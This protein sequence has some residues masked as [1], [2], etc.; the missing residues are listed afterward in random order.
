MRKQGG[1]A[2]L[3]HKSISFGRC[4]DRAVQNFIDVG[5]GPLPAPVSPPGG[6]KAA[7]I[8]HG[9]AFLT[10]APR[11]TATPWDPRGHRFVA[12][13]CSSFSLCMG[14]GALVGIKQSLSVN[15]RLFIYV[16]DHLL[17]R[18]AHAPSTREGGGSSSAIG[19]L[20]MG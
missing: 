13:P 1:P 4:V 2:L 15:W 16:C 8:N 17:V 18:C 19:V 5:L 14:F 10:S 7:P 20:P 9:N 11:A 12:S 6:V 3:V